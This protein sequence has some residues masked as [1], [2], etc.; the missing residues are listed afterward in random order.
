MIGK[1]ADL[2]GTCSKS[3]LGLKPSYAM[4]NEMSAMKG[5]G[6]GGGMLV[7]RRGRL[8]CNVGDETSCLS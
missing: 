6:N 4:A 3:M 7:L 2:F 5:A 8:Y 1:S